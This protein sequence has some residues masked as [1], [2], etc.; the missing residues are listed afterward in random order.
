MAYKHQHITISRED[1]EY[2]LALIE[3]KREIRKEQRKFIKAI[4]TELR[5]KKRI[6]RSSAKSQS[7]K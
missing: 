6:E 1:H 5:A 7:L 3:I 4:K 2:R